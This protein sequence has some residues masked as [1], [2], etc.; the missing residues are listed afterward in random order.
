MYLNSKNGNVKID[1]YDMDYIAFGSGSKTLIIITGLGDGLKTVKGTAVPFGVMYREFGKDYRVYVFSRKNQL[2][3]GYTTRD[4]AKE[5]VAAMKKLKIYNASIIGVSQGGMIA[6]YVAIDYPEVVDKLVLVVTISRPNETIKNVVSRWIEMSKRN[7]Y[8]SIIIDTTEKSYSEKSIKKQRIMYPIA[9]RIGKP[10]DFSRFIIQAEACINHNSYEELNKIKCKT[11]VI[12]GDNDKIV[13][14]NSSEEIAERIENS[15]LI[16]YKG[17]GHSV[18]EEE[19][20]FKKEVL[21][22]LK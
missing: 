15:K 4:M 14:Q 6:Q 9:T 8:K 20:G 5:L 13:G 7:D 2:V 16:I 12:G 22:F 17:L 11:L 10:K 21:K 18:H 1:N 19:K 3:N